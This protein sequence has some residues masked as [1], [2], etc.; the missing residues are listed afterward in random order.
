MGDGLGQKRRREEERRVKG[1]A[2]AA[3]DDILTPCIIVDV[4]CN[5]AEGGDL[6]G[7]LLEAGVVLPNAASF[8]SLRVEAR[9]VGRGLEGRKEKGY[10]VLARRRRT[11]LRSRIER[12]SQR[13]LCWNSEFGVCNRAEAMS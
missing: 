6:G 3:I 5:A 4:D 9:G 13:G 2:Y 1:G 11:C 8:V 10:T 12:G 7:E